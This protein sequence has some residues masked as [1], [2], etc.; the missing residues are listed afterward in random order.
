MVCS[1]ASYS[2]NNDEATVYAPFS[3]IDT[4]GI[5]GARAIAILASANEAGKS[6][7]FFNDQEYTG[8]WEDHEGDPQ[9]GFSVYD[10]TDVLQDGTN[11]ARIQSFDAGAN[12]D[13]MYAMATILVTEYTDSALP[14][15]TVTAIKP[16][17]GAGDNIFANEPNGIS[18]MVENL[19]RKSTRLNSSH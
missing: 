16:N 7:F 15:L 4:A 5:T 12:G 3:G 13:S 19:D 11:E 6:K 14:D 8:F 10:V 1:R 18:V 9:I 17:A 2:V